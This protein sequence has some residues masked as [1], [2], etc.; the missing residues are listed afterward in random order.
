[1]EML[2][3]DRFVSTPRAPRPPQRAIP[4]STGV[5]RVMDRTERGKTACRWCISCRS[6]GRIGQ[7]IRWRSGWRS[8]WRIR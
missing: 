6:G 1:M 5:A 3:L 2:F 7:R 8:G 4:I